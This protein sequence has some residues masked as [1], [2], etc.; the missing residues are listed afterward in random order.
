MEFR[1]SCLKQQDKLTYTHRTI[2][3]IY[4]VYE[5]GASDSFNEDQTRKNSLFG[6]VNLTT[7]AEIDKY[8]YSSYGI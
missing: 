5:L 6:A 1:R 3:N 8:R 7:N 4:I 2:V